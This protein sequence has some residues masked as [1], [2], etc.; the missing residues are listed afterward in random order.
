M[1]VGFVAIV[2]EEMASIALNVPAHFGWLAKN[3]AIALLCASKSNPYGRIYVNFIYKL[4]QP[5]EDRTNEARTRFARMEGARAQFLAIFNAIST[6]L[7][8]RYAFSTVAHSNGHYYFFGHCS[9]PFLCF[10]WHC[11]GFGAFSKKKTRISCCA[12]NAVA[13]SIALSC[14][15]QFRLPYGFLRRIFARFTR[16]CI[17]ICGRMQPMH[18]HTAANAKLCAII[19]LKAAKLQ[20]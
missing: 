16:K 17:H 10:V 4:A 11:F 1:R 13:V 3:V 18:T 12:P 5:S 6:W 20:E 8:L 9:L 2:Y 15:P 14:P 19:V 7:I